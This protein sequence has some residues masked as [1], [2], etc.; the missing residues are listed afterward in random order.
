MGLGYDPILEGN[1]F[2]SCAR[3]Q[4]HGKKSLEQLRQKNDKTP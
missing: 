2:F 3:W 1:G 4:N